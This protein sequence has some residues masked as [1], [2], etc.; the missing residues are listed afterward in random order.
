MDYS[1]LDSEELIRAMRHNTEI[2]LAQQDTDEL[3]MMIVREARLDKQALKVCIEL[4]PI[5]RPF[6]K[7]NAVVGLPKI[8]QIFINYIATVTGMN[9]KAFAEED[10]A[11]EWL[12]Q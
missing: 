2:S 3:L 11:R 5:M 4:A 1:G 7:K 10:E 9:I 8:R 6:V 12:V